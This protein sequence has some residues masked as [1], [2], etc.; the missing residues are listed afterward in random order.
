MSNKPKDVKRLVEYILT[1]GERCH[2][3]MV[4]EA[5][6]Q[7]YKHPGSKPMRILRNIVP[8]KAT[9]LSHSLR[10]LFSK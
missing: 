6:K 5:K 1:V 10:R 3:A 8:A 2:I 4:R 7:G 9:L